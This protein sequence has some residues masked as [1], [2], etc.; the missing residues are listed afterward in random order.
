MQF[1]CKIVYGHKNVGLNEITKQ[2]FKT[3]VELDLLNAVIVWGLL[4]TLAS[5]IF[6]NLH[7]VMIGTLS[8]LDIC[9]D[10]LLLQ[11]AYLANVIGSDIGALLSPIGT[12]AML[13]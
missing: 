3:Y 11:V 7:T 6:N 9:L 1:V 12:L 5:Y 2:T 13:I 10:P 8:I 4:S